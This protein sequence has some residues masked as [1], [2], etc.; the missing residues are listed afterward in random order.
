MDN[1]EARLMKAR[2]QFLRRGESP[3]F[4][5]ILLH[6][7]FVR[8]GVPTAATDGHTLWWNPQY[9]EKLSDA[10][11]RGLL[12]HE[13]MHV[14]RAHHMR[15]GH[16]D[17]ERWNHACDAAID[18]D[19]ETAGY[20]VPDSFAKAPQWAW[21]KGLSAEVIYARMPTENP[22]GG[23]VARAGAVC[24]TPAPETEDVRQQIMIRQAAMAQ[25]AADQGS[26][27]AWLKSLVGELV[28]PKVN[29]RDVLRNFLGATVP[30]QYSFSPPNRR[31]RAQGIYLPG[32]VKQGVSEGVVLL[33][34]SG[35]MN[36]ERQRL[37]SETA[38][39]IND[40]PRER[41]HVLQ[42]DAA[43]GD[44]HTYEPDDTLELSV[45]G[46][47]GSDFRPAF[48]AIEEAGLTPE[49]MVVISDMWIDFPKDAPPYPVLA[50]STTASSGPE[51]AINCRMED[52]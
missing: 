1:V 8:G 44:I 26:T 52:I 2:V 37:L 48:R 29:W 34:T 6:H 28:A 31:Y 11:L 46:G 3:F 20:D 23:G 24:D 43:V 45:V 39:I 13:V 51:W 50:F 25:R 30:A 47:G 10:Q 42:C 27:P 19:L 40:L 12:A 16:R 18:W 33:D 15:R 22:S 49:W 14:A 41:V 9:I 4:A 17:H 38:A 36:G 7:K 5:T 21:A 32:I 35:S